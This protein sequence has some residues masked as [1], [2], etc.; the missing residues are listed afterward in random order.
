MPAKSTNRRKKPVSRDLIVSFL[1]RTLRTN[2]IKDYSVN[3]LQVEGAEKVSRVGLAVD[4]CMDTFRL[5]EE[6]G[7][8]M[9]IAHHGIIWNGIQRVTGPVYRQ[10]QFLI[11]KKLNLYAS[12]L[13]LD[14]HPT[15]GNNARIAS[16]LKLRNVRPFGVYKG[17]TIGCEGT[18]TRA[19]TIE[20]ISG[21][22]KKE[23]GS[24][25]HSLPFGPEKIKRIAVISGGGSGELPEAVEKGIDL[26][27]TG[28]SSHENHHAALE[29]SLNVI[30]CGHYHSEKPGV[31]AVGELLVEKFGLDTVFL[32]VP[33]LV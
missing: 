29:G 18:L 23:L 8:Q 11:G 25:I 2:E 16:M 12:H 19:A 26:F 30:Y 3:G 22:L 20:S 24:E 7:C 14:L 5:A 6:S 27:I 9:L 15:L 17:V 33:T 32:D 10:L 21:V 28:E 13:P 4:A 1:D 31:Q